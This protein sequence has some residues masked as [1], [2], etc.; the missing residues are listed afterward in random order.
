[1][2]R[3]DFLF[4]FCRLKKK[5]NIYD[6]L[7][8]VFF[9]IDKVSDKSAKQLIELTKKTIMQIIINDTSVDSREVAENKVSPIP[10]ETLDNEETECE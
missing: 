8:E 7:H 6:Y 3:F 4:A 9:V 2:R 5:D 1:M 10:E